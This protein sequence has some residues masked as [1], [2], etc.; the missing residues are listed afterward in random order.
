M[1]GEDPREEPDPQ[2]NPFKGTPLE[3]LFGPGGPGQADLAGMFA[4]MQEM[5]SGS[6]DG[7]INFT[8]A[9]DTARQLT[10][11]KGPDPS[12]DSR[13][14]AAVE[15]AVQLAEMW[16]DRA[17]DLPSAT[18]S[19]QAWSRAEWIEQTMDRWQ[20][21]VEPIAGNVMSS[22][23]DAM[24]EE[25]R[26][27]AGP[28]MTIMTQAGGALFSQQIG[29]SVAGLAAEVLS[30]T[31]IGLPMGPDGVAALVPH[32]IEAFAEGLEDAS[33]ADLVLYT[34]LRECA[35]HRLYAH[36]PWLRQ[37]IIAAVEEFGAD[38]RINTEAIEEQ[39]RSFDPTQA[40]DLMAQIS[41]GMLEPQLT[42]GQL[43]ARERLELLLALGEGWVD[44]VVAQATA[45]T[46]PNAQR[47]AEAFR[48]RRATEGPAE[49]TFIALVGLELHPRRLRD[50]ATLFAALRG[51]EGA[52]ARDRV[53][54]HPD[55]LPTAEDLDDPLGYGERHLAPGQL[56]D[57]DFD[58]ALGKLLDDEAGRDDQ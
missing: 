21:L 39:M 56:S 15:D 44:E 43:R 42:S 27:L 22:M 8:A 14:R 32:N 33:N 41:E 20:P 9:R 3:H 55:L 53:W 17:T 29:Q 25:A 40:D 26:A 35:Q 46:M 1:A 54:S 11:A 23:A 45:E 6:S 28:L 31:D 30:S 36:A 4:K 52:E 13:D 47:L 51:R 7:G 5:F 2:E 48:R 16:L 12:A 18:T 50:A 19:V 37:A 57:D 24:P 58:A 10:A 49:Q 38:A 34:A